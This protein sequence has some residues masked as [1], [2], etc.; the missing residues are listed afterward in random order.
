[1]VPLITSSEA[2][3]F[4]RRARDCC[5]V[6]WRRDLGFFWLRIRQLEGGTSHE[7]EWFFRE[8]LGPEVRRLGIPQGRSDSSEALAPKNDANFAQ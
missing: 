2:V 8:S 1:M 6:D 7:G 5:H 3:G 4:L